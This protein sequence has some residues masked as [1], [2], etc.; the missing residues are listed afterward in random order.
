MSEYGFWNCAKRDPDRTV[1]IETESGNH[2]KA[3]Q[4]A[5]AS[6]RLV[7]ALRGL[8]LKSGD[9]VAT[10]L[11]NC[12]AM[13]EVYLAAFQAGF[14]LVPIN[15]HLTTPEIAYIVSDCGA[16]VLIGHHEF[17]DAIIGAADEAGLAA[18]M[19]VAVGEVE[20]F[21]CYD[22]LKAG[23]PDAEPDGRTAGQ[24][25]NYTSGTTGRPKGVRR[26][27]TGADPDLMGA[28]Y[29][30]FLSMFG[31]QPEDD[32]VHLCGSPLYHTAV[33]MFTAGSLHYGHT[34]VLMERWKPED[35]LRVIESYKVTTSHM[36]PTQFHRMLALP[37]DVKSRYDMSSLRCMIHAAAPC[38]VEVKKRMIEWWGQ[39]IFEYYAASEGGGTLV[40][41]AEW[42]Q[43]P[44]TVG[45]AWA[46]S[47]IKIFDD[48]GDGHECESDEKGT[49]YMLL[50][51]NDF[52]YHNDEEKT[53]E[54]RRQGY[55]TV[56]DIGYLNS[57]GYLFLCDR[58]ADM[59]ISGGVNIYPAEIESVLL[60]HPKIADAAVFGIPHEDWG[61]EV[62]AVIQAAD[63]Q[64]AGQTLCDDIQAFCEDKL[65][66]YKRPRT[67]D[68]IEDMP[69][70]PN[71]K[72]YKRKLRDPYWEG[73]DRAI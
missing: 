43:Y 7:H 29:A 5:S 35:C 14:Y 39:T 25:M 69:R 42:Q 70:D 64:E 40:P 23:Q 46:G 17:A 8:G 57:D 36:V 20:G 52:R 34:V 21:R 24:V 59:I 53:E 6:H 47:D 1:V 2:I 30:M 73:H 27:L 4:L 60:T 28:M 71:G 49:V 45:R 13:L 62:K 65:A 44:G 41:P 63:G 55:F 56:G 68:F 54:N 72:L 18:D 32:N 12:T 10:V 50:G 3:G 48:D 51:S 58:K 38:P 19:R 67:I 16:R 11:P 61:E 37:E 66:K 9:V 22:E 31:I 33:L 26:G 15:H